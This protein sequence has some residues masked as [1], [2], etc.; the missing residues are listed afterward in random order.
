VRALEPFARSRGFDVIT[1][2]EAKP[3]AAN[4]LIHGEWAVVPAGYPETT[5]RIERAGFRVQRI[6][7]SEF[8]KRDCGV[9]CLSVLYWTSAIPRDC[10][11]G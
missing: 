6:S 10:G 5:A 4:V 3:S 11:G 8:E 9:T 1:V 7:V 2:A